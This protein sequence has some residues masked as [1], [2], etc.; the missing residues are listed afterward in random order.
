[1]VRGLQ[2]CGA[3]T[4][5]ASHGNRR[6][7]AALGG[8]VVAAAALAGACNQASVECDLACFR[9]VTFDL[10][11]PVDAQ[12][13][14]VTVRNEA[15]GASASTTC[16]AAADGMISCTG[17]LWP[18]LDGEMRLQAVTWE[19]TGLGPLQFEMTDGDQTTAQE[20]TEA[21]TPIG[22]ACGTTCYQPQQVVVSD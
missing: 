2:N 13:V 9:T 16:A 1:V 19:S 10:A 21:P 14:T 11:T 22:D 5:T 18:T 17:T 3:M 8:L 6:L 7:R 20:L 4:M 12:A 15:T